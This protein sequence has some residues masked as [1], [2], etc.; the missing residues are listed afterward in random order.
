MEEE[1]PPGGD[2]NDRSEAPADRGRNGYAK[3]RRP[4]EAPP[5]RGRR[6]GTPPEAGARHQ[7]QGGAE[8]RQRPALT[9]L[10]ASNAEGRYVSG[11]AGR[12][13]RHSEL[14]QNQYRRPTHAKRTICSY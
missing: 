3:P 2:D 1:A 6:E 13:L 11:F 7:T 12:G 9:K 10:I 14:T 5:E 4:T 8:A